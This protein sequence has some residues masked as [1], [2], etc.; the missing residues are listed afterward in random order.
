MQEVEELGDEL[1][2]GVSEAGSEF[3]SEEGCGSNVR[4]RPGWRVGETQRATFGLGSGQEP[5]Y[6]YRHDLDRS[7]AI[8]D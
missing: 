7:H 5:V 1:S 4:S 8:Y 3:G 6:I 2:A